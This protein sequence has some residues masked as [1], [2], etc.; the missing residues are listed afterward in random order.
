MYFR[1]VPYVFPSWMKKS[2]GGQQLQSNRY[3]K[4]S[5]LTYS[6][7]LLGI[8]DLLDHP[9]PKDPAQADAYTLYIQNRKEYDT[10]VKKQAESFRNP[11]L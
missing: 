11:N 2:T 6:K 4:N 5:F 3:L 7:I 10:R 9:N 1:L 8:Q